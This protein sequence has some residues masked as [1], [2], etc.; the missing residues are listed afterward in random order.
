MSVQM[1]EQREKA[2]RSGD[3][4]DDVGLLDDTFVMPRLG[5]KN[6]PSVIG[7]SKDRLRMHRRH[8]WLRAK[9]IFR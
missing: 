2:M 3:L 5:S 4:P 9:E 8:L 1:K 7:H 6:L